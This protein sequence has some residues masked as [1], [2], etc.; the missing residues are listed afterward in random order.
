MTP[1][2]LATTNPF[3]LATPPAWFLAQLYAYDTELRIFASTSR[4]VYQ[5]GRRGRHGHT[6]GKPDPKLPDTYVFHRHGIWPWKEIVPQEIG[7]GWGRILLDLPE[8]DTQRFTDPAGQLDRVEAEAEAALDRRIADEADQ[9]AAAMYRT[10]GLIEGSRTGAGSRPAGAG[11]RKL[12]AHHP[13]ARRPR[14]SRSRA[15]SGAGAIWTGR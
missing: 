15:P 5:L 8:Y 10:Y 1:N 4:P 14:A 13:R 7:F 12:G 11:Y 2:Y 3:A 6:I 9:R